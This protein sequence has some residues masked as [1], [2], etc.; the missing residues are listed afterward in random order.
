MRPR[1]ALVLAVLLGLAQA[2][3]AAAAG[4][5]ALVIGNQDYATLPDLPNAA[6][7]A[8]LVADRLAR[9]GFAVA[10]ARDVD[11][12]GLERAVATFLEG[13]RDAEAALVYFAGH[14]VQVDGVNWL[15]PTSAAV[16][17]REDLAREGLALDRLLE[18][19][20]EAGPEVGV[21]I[22]D[23]CRDNPLGALPGAARVGAGRGLG[24]S[25]GLART[26]APTGLFIAYA[27]APGQVAFDGPPGGNGPFARALA[28]LVEQP[29]LEISILFRRVREQVMAMTA[30]LQQ[31]WTE[32][33]LTRE[34]Y[35]VPPDPAA[36][37]PLARL[38]RALAEADP[39]R[40]AAGLAEVARAE[41]ASEPGRLAAVELAADRAR[42]AR[43]RP[44]PE[45]LGAAFADRQR[46]L[47]LAGT[48][49]GELA[50]RAYAALHGAPPPVERRARGF[51]PATGA[52]TPAPA[53]SPAQS[54]ASSP[55]ATPTP[56]PDGLVWP[57]V[58]RARRS[59]LVE[60][61]LALFPSS[62]HAE[63][64][65]LALAVPPPAAPTD[66]AAAPPADPPEPA[67]AVTV[68]LGTGPRPLPLPAGLGP[69]ALAAP[70]ESGRLLASTAEGARIELGAEPVAATAL[71]FEPYAYTRDRVEPVDLRGAD[72]TLALRLE[73]KIAT[74]PCDLE[75]GS[76]FDTQG[77]ALGRYPNEVD[78]EP[79]IAA[80]LEAVAAYPEV[81][82]LRGQLGRARVLAGRYALGVADY[83]AAAAA[84]HLVSMWNLGSL[85]VEGRGVPRDLA[86]GVALLEAAAAKGNPGAMN[87]LGRLYLRGTGVPRDRDRAVAWLEQAAAAG[88]TF[89]YNN[90]GTL[91]L[92]EG[93]AAR[94]RELFT[95]SAE[96]GD[97][98]GYN[99]LGWLHETGRGVERDLA[100]ALRWYAKAAE[101]GQPH[102]FVNLGRLLRKGGPGLPSDPEQAAYWLAAGAE[103]G[104]IWGHVQL[105]RL[106]LAGA[107]GGKDEVAAAR[108]LAR[109]ATA[110]LER[111]PMALRSGITAAYHE[112]AQ[113]AARAALAELPQAALVRAI[114]DELAARGLDP[115][116]RD[117]RLGPRTRAA[118][119]AFARAQEPP[120]PEAAPLW[121][122]LGALLE[123]AA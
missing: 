87:E 81:A 6:A 19:L 44:R 9:V 101:A 12:A 98:F 85:L 77:V 2:G 90:L 20:R 53:P 52:G 120:L 103:R 91:L 80:C 96:A 123:P 75:A 73:L 117:G 72:G 17:A 23:A 63:E 49:A 24:P 71:A 119:A 34:L 93:A 109:A 76:R 45:P 61:F 42:L 43:A 92:E 66:A 39:W 8:R 10:L 47:L 86:R 15:L 94:A 111:L 21:V 54:P 112:E 35:L 74:H 69:L 56:A 88:H 13:S 5:V 95:A 38:N 107:G 58:E 115:G 51:R 30:G 102:A 121:Q 122:V 114:Q 31:P 78:P 7:D 11:R 62:A 16:R 82:R 18:R 1:L 110:R 105:A 27:T 37:D 25:R 4:R 32:E 108:L 60:R 106:Q 70:L 55:A 89:A 50:A 100:A 14:G 57:L 64:A 79:A 99:N 59:D 67:A 3:P 83:E 65:R 36:P 46:V 118:I 68:H 97:I 113:A 26:G 29:G 104:N 22:L 84:G 41:P 28:A 33:S 48:P 116:G 40:R